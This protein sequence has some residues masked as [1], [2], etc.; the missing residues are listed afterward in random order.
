MEAQNLV[1]FASASRAPTLPSRAVNPVG[2][3]FLLPV[4]VFRLCCRKDNASIIFQL[5]TQLTPPPAP[6]ISHFHFT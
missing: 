2:E 5:K 6:S 4:V 1:A 3:K